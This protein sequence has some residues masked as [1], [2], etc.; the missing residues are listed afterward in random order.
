MSEALGDE[1]MSQ[2][3][4]AAAQAVQTVHQLAFGKVLEF[5]VQQARYFGLR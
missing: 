3:D 1:V 5:S 2:S 4:V